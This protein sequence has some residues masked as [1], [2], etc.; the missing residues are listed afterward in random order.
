VAATL[1][2]NKMTFPCLEWMNRCNVGSW[3]SAIACSKTKLRMMVAIVACTI[4]NAF[5]G[6]NFWNPLW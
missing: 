2:I 1:L 6:D 3:S 5:I 4:M